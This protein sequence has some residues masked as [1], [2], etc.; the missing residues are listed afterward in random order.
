MKTAHTR[1]ITAIAISDVDESETQQKTGDNLNTN[2]YPSP[3]I[4]SSGKD[5]ILNIWLPKEAVVC[6]KIS[7]KVSSRILCISIFV[8]SKSSKHFIIMG[9]DN[10][11]VAVYDLDRNEMI[12]KFL[13]H[14][15][16]VSCVSWAYTC[17][18][19]E[20]KLFNADHLHIFS[21]SK[22][23]TI[24]IWRFKEENRRRKLKHSRSVA[25][26]AVA[27]KSLRTVVVSGCSNGKMYLWDSFD[28]VLL[29]VLEGHV[30]AVTSVCLWETDE[31]LIISGSVDKSIR[32][33]S[34]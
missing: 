12:K 13:G 34:A 26:M 8:H 7:P 29:Q 30:A 11:E 14:V 20:E 6:K 32:V 24:R 25:C 18:N 23:K 9:L 17:P 1:G 21:G 16:Q 10:G 27:K 31:I 19:P 33:V 15:L 4:C 28:G 2:S 3:I 5:D 22:D